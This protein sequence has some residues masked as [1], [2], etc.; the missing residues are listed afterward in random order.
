MADA[1][2]LVSIS[3]MPVSLPEALPAQPIDTAQL[4]P[5]IR[6]K[7]EAEQPLVAAGVSVNPPEATRKPF[8]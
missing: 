5:G 7:A 3:T 1:E 4:C 6:S 2:A 8:T